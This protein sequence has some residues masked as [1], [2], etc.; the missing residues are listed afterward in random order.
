MSQERRE[1]LREDEIRRLIREETTE[2]PDAA[3]QG[4]AIA[5][6]LLQSSS[7]KLIKPLIKI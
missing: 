5:D 2:R 1:D 6:P 3:S 7:S 4:A